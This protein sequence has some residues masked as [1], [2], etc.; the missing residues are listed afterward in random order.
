V[1]QILVIAEI[2]QNRIMPVTFELAG[3]ALEIACLKTQME[4]CGEESVFVKGIFDTISGCSGKNRFE[5]NC[6]EE[7]YNNYEHNCKVTRF[8]EKFRQIWNFAGEMI[9]SIKIA[10]PGD[11]PVLLAEKIAE[12]TAMDV[13]PLKISSFESYN[14]DAYKTSLYNLISKMDVSHVLAAHTSQGRDFAP[15]LSLKLDAVFISGVNSVSAGNRESESVSAYEPM[16][17]TDT[18]PIFLH[19]HVYSRKPDT[20]G[21]KSNGRLEGKI[22]VGKLYLYSRFVF[23]NA[24]N[25]IIGVASDLSVVLTVMPGMFKF[26]RRGLSEKNRGNRRRACWN[27]CCIIRVRPWA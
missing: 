10:V 6:K 15:G 21:D 8:D 11:D 9:D 26:I 12:H 13:I 4:Y 17:D 3:A 16:H 23:E 5:N 14:S 22:C 20:S 27:E 25:M 24:F 2:F 18:D 1:K 19:K 7:I